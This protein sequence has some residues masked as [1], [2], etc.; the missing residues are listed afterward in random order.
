VNLI[1]SNEL[2]VGHFHV[3]VIPRYLDTP[4]RLPWESRPGDMEVIKAAAAQLT[5]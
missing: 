2:D 1:S 4:V 5:G 3:N